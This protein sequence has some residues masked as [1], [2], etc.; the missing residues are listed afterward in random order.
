MRIDTQ[1]PKEK[2]IILMSKTLFFATVFFIFL[3]TVVQAQYRPTIHY[4]F[5]GKVNSIHH[6]I[7][8]SSGTE[9][10]GQEN[11]TGQSGTGANID[12]IYH[13]IFW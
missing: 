13:K 11:F 7:L 8:N 9:G 10:A 12:V 4:P 3:N 6:A 1:Y 2:L 5:P